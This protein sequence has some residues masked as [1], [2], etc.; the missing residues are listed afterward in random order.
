MPRWLYLVACLLVA[1][2]WTPAEEWSQVFPVTGVPE[3]RIK[4]NGGHVGVTP[5]SSAEVRVTVEARGYQ[6]DRDY[7]VRPHQ[8]ANRIEVEVER[9][10]QGGFAL[11]PDR[12]LRVKVSVPGRSNLEVESDDG[13][14]SLAGINGSVKARTGDGHISAYN[15]EGTLELKSGGGHITAELVRG[16][17]AA[18][19]GDGDV[20]A[21]GRFE[22]L[23]VETGDGAVSLRV[24]P[25]STMR[26]HWNVRTGDG[27]IHLA[28]PDDL[29]ADL[30]AS[31]SDGRIHSE[32]PGT[33]QT[34]GNRSS[35]RAKL[36]GGGN[37]LTVRSED[38]DI[39]ITRR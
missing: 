31:A 15:M 22:G 17:L 37:L 16:S 13:D 3:V 35:F 10:E 18:H 26:G 2:G 7:Q 23:Q 24:E 9:T 8:S 1:A 20:T 4:V 34:S 11:L 12:S 36:N 6:R 14:L 28:L 38:G 29:A 27:A 32:F 21:R 19:A 39:R 30:D 5:G 33:V 25:G